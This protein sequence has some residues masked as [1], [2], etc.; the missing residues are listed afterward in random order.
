MAGLDRHRVIRVGKGRGGKI[1]CKHLHVCDYK[2]VHPLGPKRRKRSHDLDKSFQALDLHHSK[3]AFCNC[4]D[5]RKP[6]QNRFAL[7]PETFLWCPISFPWSWRKGGGKEETFQA[8]DE[9]RAL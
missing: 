5:S 6:P 8:K 4:M 7:Q 3:D 9:N 1:L 2:P